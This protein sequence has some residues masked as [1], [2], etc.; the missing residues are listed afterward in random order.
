VSVGKSKVTSEAADETASSAGSTG[1][2]VAQA[3]SAARSIGQL[4][5]LK[6]AVAVSPP[7]PTVPGSPQ[8]PQ[9]TAGD[10]SVTVSWS[11]PGSNGG[12]PITGYKIYRRTS[13]VAEAMVATVTSTSY[14]DAGLTNGTTY[15]Y[16]ISA[17]NTV[18]E[19]TKSIEVSATPAAA[20]APSAPLGL[21]ASGGKPHGI[22]LSW[23]APA[24]NGGSATIGYKVYRG[25][26]GGT[27]VLLVSLGNVTSYKDTT[28]ARG[29][30]YYYVVTA[31]N[32][33]GESLP[34]TEASAVAR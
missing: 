7:P 14:L 13:T 28:A 10:A 15:Y 23:S 29:V 31:V 8:S 30:T 18:G 5:A 32:A 19:S 12:S 16:R 27:Y 33:A 22:A 4:V 3:G 1:S 11:P 6:P 26:T 34:S 9:A 21:T 17:V 20:T 25:T 2:R 24:S